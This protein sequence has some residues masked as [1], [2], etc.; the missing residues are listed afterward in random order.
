MEEP[1]RKRREIGESE[2]TPQRG[3]WGGLKEG[4]AHLYRESPEKRNNNNG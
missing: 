4:V 3:V 2:R 1:E